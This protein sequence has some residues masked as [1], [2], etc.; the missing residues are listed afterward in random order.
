MPDTPTVGLWVVAEVF[1]H[2]TESIALAME[3]A[4]LTRKQ[5]RIAYLVTCC[6]ASFRDAAEQAGIDVKTAHE[7]YR[8]AQRKIPGLRQLDRR[9]PATVAMSLRI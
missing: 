6:G 5:A 7:H 4:G 8:S 3:A 9:K 1:Q 2:D